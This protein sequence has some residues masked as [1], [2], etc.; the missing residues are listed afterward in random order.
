[1]AR[2]VTNN[3]VTLPAFRAGDKE[4]GPMLSVTFG[5]GARLAFGEKKEYAVSLA[6]EMIYSRFLNHLY[7][8][9][10]FGYFGA[11]TFE[12]EFE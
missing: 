4:L 3:T 1:M 9:Q 6:A 8:L 11:T 2:D 7:I 12:V 10:R 5:G